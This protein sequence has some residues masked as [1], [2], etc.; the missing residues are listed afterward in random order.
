M[1][2]F[3]I[4][5]LL[6][7]IP[8]LLGVTLILFSISH[9]V[10]GDPVATALGP[11][12]TEEAVKQLKEAWGMDKPVFYQYVDYLKGLVRG[13]LGFSVYT[14]RPVSSAIQDYFASTFELAIVSFAM[15]VFF[16]VIAGAIIATY[17]GT[18][19]DHLVRPLTIFGASMPVFWVGILVLFIFYHLLGIIPVGGR[20]GA[21]IEFQPTI[22]GMYLLDSIITG[23]WR[24]LLSFLHHIIGPAFCLSLSPLAIITRQTRSSLLEIMGKD[25]IRTARAKGL[26]EK[27]VISKHALK[28]SL[29]PIITI[30]GIQF[31]Y[32]ISRSVIAEVIFSWPGLGRYAI[33]AIKHMDLQPVLGFTLIITVF[34]IMVNLGVD[35]LYAYVNPKIKY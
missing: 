12:A 21:Q 33:D 10:P 16:G 15:A 7:I 26:K 18:I 20:I 32:L 1:I 19:V 4:K 30:G 25:Y 35:V 29:I 23:N 31:G 5:R 28:N 9:L 13:D 22:T 14:G 6:W 2:T 34:Y 27:T 11:S 24:A 8:I 17:K 3:T